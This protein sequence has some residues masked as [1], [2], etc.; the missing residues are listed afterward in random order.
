MTLIL[1]G[2]IETAGGHYSGG[3]A[4]DEAFATLPSIFK[5]N[6]GYEVLKTK[7]NEE[8][9]IVK[10]EFSI[11]PMNE[12]QMFRFSDFIGRMGCTMNMYPDGQKKLR[13]VLEE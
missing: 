7:K 6:K 9:W 1:K 12:E 8:D 5:D 3:T 10:M 4:L 11:N 13:I 2:S